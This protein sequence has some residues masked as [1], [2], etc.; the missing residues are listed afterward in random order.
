MQAHL[1]VNLALADTLSFLCLAF[2]FHL[3]RNLAN[4][5]ITILVKPVFDDLGSLEDL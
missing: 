5:R 4:N 2:V 1:G 3:T